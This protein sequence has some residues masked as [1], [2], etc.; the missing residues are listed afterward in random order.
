M[1]HPQAAVT[2]QKQGPLQKRFYKTSQRSVVNRNASSRHRASA[3]LRICDPQQKRGWITKSI[4]L[5]KDP[6]LIEQIA[7][8]TRIYKTYQPTR[9]ANTDNT[10]LS[11]P[12]ECTDNISTN[13]C[14]QLRFSISNYNSSQYNR[15]RN[16]IQY[17]DYNNKVS[18]LT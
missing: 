6:A 17:F 3:S 9:K 7:A 5:R 12:F 13:T 18:Y 14:K 2:P 16:R 11:L 1:Q 8:E 15:K 4:F 10:A